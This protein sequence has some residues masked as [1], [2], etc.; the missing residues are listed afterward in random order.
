MGCLN[1]KYTISNNNVLS[2]IFIYK[3]TDQLK[4]DTDY[5]DKHTN[6]SSNILKEQVHLNNDN[7]NLNLYSEHISEIGKDA[8][9]YKFLSK[10]FYE[11][12]NISI[13]SADSKN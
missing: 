9:V 1:D 2:E 6:S 10:S 8:S 12:D 7:L 11:D 4:K 5:N 13:S 3:E